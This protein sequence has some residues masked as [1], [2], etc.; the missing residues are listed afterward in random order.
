M[1]GRS[2]G[3]WSGPPILRF[4][5]DFI[6]SAPEEINGWFGVV[7]VPPAPPFPE[8]FH[9]KKMCAIV[10]C[11]TGALEGRGALQADPR[12]RPR[13]RSTSPGRSP[14]HVCRAC[15]TR[16]SR[17]G[18]QWYWKA[19]FFTDLTDEAIE[20]PREVRRA[21]CRRC[22]RRCI[23]TRSTARYIVSATP[24]PRSASAMR[25]SPR[26]SSG[27]IRTQQQRA[28]DPVGQG[29]LGGAASRTRWAAATST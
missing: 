14:G 20:L 25:T 7:T 4:W 27:S 29:L 21:S 8:Q 19:D 10:W 26:S 15:S 11:F 1:A 9:L 3:R 5:R 28:H 23:C 6:L 24:T 12:V 13:R 18:L 2:S 17:P 16:C 22:I